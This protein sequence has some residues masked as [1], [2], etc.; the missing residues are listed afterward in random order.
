L[1]TPHV[2]RASPA[3]TRPS[4]GSFVYDY[5]FT[6]TGEADV[7]AGTS[8]SGKKNKVPV[9]DFA[10]YEGTPGSGKLL[11]FSG[12]PMKLAFA[13]GSTGAGL[14]GN[15]GWELDAGK[16]YVAVYG[17]SNSALPITGNVVTTAVPEIPT[18][19]MFGA[20]FLTLGL[21]A[22]KQRKDTRYAI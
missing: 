14:G 11:S 19:A 7:T 13:N 15:N 20:G 8:I 16:Y 3:Q 17:T 4:K 21:A 9:G 18:W 5:T 6:L 1:T 22:F 10:L 12:N 2:Y